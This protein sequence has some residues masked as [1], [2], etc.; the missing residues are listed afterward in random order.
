ML[1]G[2]E[3]QAHIFFLKFKMAE[4]RE[5]LVDDAKLAE[6]AERMTKWLKP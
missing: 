5:D 2:E 3:E 4:H 1:L 6:Q